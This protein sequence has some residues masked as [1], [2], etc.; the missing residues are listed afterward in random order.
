MVSDVIK[1]SG[2][3]PLEQINIS[4]C[5]RASKDKSRFE[6][7]SYLFVCMCMGWEERQVPECKDKCVEVGEF[8]LGLSPF[9]MWIPGIELRSSGLA[10]SNPAYRVLTSHF[11]HE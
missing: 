11:F 3:S 8:L 2:F 1:A 4:K 10:A 7:Y 5:D 6:N 9:I